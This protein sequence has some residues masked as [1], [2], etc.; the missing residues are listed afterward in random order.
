MGRC[1]AGRRRGAG[2]EARE[3]E[4]M[5]FTER[6]LWGAGVGSIAG[7]DEVGVGPLAGPVVAAAVVLPRDVAIDGVRDSKALGAARREELDRAIREVA[8]H[9]GVGVVE[10]V[11]VDRLNVHRAGLRAM[12][13]AVEALPVAPQHLLIDARRI[14]E[15]SIPQ[16]CVVDGDRSVYSI[17]SASIVAK[18]HRDRLMREMDGRYP[19]YG[20]ARNAGYGTAEHLRALRELGPCAI[21]RR[22][23]APVRAVLPEVDAGQPRGSDVGR[24]GGSA[25]WRT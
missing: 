9:V 15:C 22:S 8:L 19:G 12:A 23:F 7:V 5:L 18:V 1:M 20:F 13:L 4:R 16:T 2:H 10:P 24:Q 3:R 21:H 17:A 25:R 6:A 11:E 14:P